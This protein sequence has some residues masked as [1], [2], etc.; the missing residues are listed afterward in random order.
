MAFENN[1]GGIRSMGRS[2]ILPAD[3]IKKL[4]LKELF[5]KY[6]IQKVI[7]FGAGTLYW[8]D[9]FEKI[10][11][12]GEGKC[13][14]VY[15]V[16]IIFQNQA[17]DTTIDYY[18]FIDDVPVKK[19]DSSCLFFI[20]DVIHHLSEKEWKTLSKKVT[21]RC[22]FIVI[23]DIDCR[24]R[25]KN[26]MNKLH[27]RII[28]GEKIR[29]VNPDMLIADLHELGYKCKMVSMHKLWYSHFLIIA[30]KKDESR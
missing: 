4:L 28:N 15:P 17:P 25:F 24:C 8:T 23:K 22:R 6:S 20:C 2:I 16:D 1:L 19:M 30:I 13:G 10:M 14:K 26:W 29:D 12:V 27:D 9:W 21:E 11:N 5:N 3:K 7:D 18:M